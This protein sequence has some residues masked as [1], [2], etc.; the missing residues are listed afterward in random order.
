[1]QKF[2]QIGSGGIKFKKRNRQ[3]N[4][5]ENNQIIPSVNI[6]AGIVENKILGPIF[7]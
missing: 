3:E 5:M 2:V 7:F 6:W 1:M 4:V